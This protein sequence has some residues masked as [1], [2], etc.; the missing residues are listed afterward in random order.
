LNP[1]LANR[2]GNSIVFRWHSKYPALCAILLVLATSPASAARPAIPDVEVKLFLDP[3]KVLD[4]N[5][6]PTQAL[7]AAFQIEDKPVGIRMEFLDGAGRE[8]E[9]AGW[10]IRLRKLTGKDYIQLTF[11]RR[12]RVTGGLDEAL[13]RAAGEG[14]DAQSGYESELDWNY[15]QQT[16]TFAWQQRAGDA[17]RDDLSLPS[18]TAARELAANRMPAE[19]RGL[20][21]KGWAEGVVARAHA[22]GPVEGQRWSGS[23]VEIDDKIAIEVWALRSAGRTGTEPVVEISFKASRYGPQAVARREKLLAL[24]QVR[25]WLLKQGGLKTERILE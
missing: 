15:Q 9:I 6:Q 13:A 1:G 25:G 14:F 21:E 11:K 7:R 10:N 16:L 4:R 5:H 24:L 23:H 20:K 22:Y 3:A 19:L 12:Y 2:K 17:D 8:L 18:A